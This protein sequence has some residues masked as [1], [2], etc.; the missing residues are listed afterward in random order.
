V[1]P[2]PGQRGPKTYR[3]LIFVVVDFG[4]NSVLLSEGSI[5]DSVT[6][7]WSNCVNNYE[8]GLGGGGW[9]ATGI[10]K[11]SVKTGYQALRY[12]SQYLLTKDFHQEEQGPTPG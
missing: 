8:R 2:P 9:G 11:C 4:M 7:S 6:R 3:I 10:C 1:E 5:L 12:S